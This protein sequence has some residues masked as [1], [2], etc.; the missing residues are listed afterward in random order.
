MYAYKVELS[1][2]SWMSFV[3]NYIFF[4]QLIHVYVQCVYFV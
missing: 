3:K 4:T 1:K 2:L